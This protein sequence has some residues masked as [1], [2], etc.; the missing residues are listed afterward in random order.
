MAH[1]PQNHVVVIDF[2]KHVEWI[3]MNKKSALEFAAMIAKRAQELPD[4]PVINSPPVEGN[5]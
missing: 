1:D 3:A 5:Q 4:V 2:G